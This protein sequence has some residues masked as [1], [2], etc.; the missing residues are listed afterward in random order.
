MSEKENE[1]VSVVVP[2]YN[3]EPYLRRC[4]DSIINQTYENMEII[5]V[6]DGSVDGS[7][8]ICGEYCKRDGRIFL[9]TQEHRGVSGARNTGI[10]AARG[11]YITFID[12]DDFVH[13]LYI[14]RLYRNLKEQ[15]AQIS[16]TGMHRFCNVLF[17]ECDR[18]TTVRVFGGIE[19]IKN[20]WYQKEI[21]NSVWAKMYETNLFKGIWFPEGMLY[22]D[23]GTVYKLFYKAQRIAVSTEVLYYYFQRP[24]SI[25]NQK[26]NE[27]KFDRIEISKELMEWAEDVE[28]RLYQAA[29]TR[30][31]VSNIQVLREI[32]LEKKY[33]NDVE[34]IWKEIK[35]YRMAVIRNREA[36]KITRFI[37][38]FS[39]GGKQ[40]LKML[41]K[42]YKYWEY[43]GL[44][45]K[46]KYKSYIITGG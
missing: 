41:G 45:R 42:Y 20:M 13:E 34:N 46:V 1:L 24:D 19:A 39:Y 35:K 4:L 40:L 2:V 8:R 7:G 22:E 36:K 31:F 29:Y 5:L 6:N 38:I 18:K 25:M 14:E 43:K 27:K 28:D 12:S 26:F 30:Y 16:C 21:T 37:A 3:V 15:R 32:P 33:E 10:N 23:L 44:G 9:L 17:T 11:K